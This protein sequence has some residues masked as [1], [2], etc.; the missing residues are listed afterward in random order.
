MFCYAYDT[1]DKAE[2]VIA[3][4]NEERTGTGR[5]VGSWSEEC[6][7]RSGERRAR[8]EEYRAR[9]EERRARSDGRKAWRVEFEL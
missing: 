5:G 4:P 9:S 7:A 1:E 2:N 6:R 3:M 8:S